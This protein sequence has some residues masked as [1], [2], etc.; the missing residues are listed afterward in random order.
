MAVYVITSVV[1]LGDRFSP[2]CPSIL[3][4]L[5]YPR[6]EFCPFPVSALPSVTSCDGDVTHELKV[7]LLLRVL[8]LP[9]TWWIILPVQCAS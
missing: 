3:S 2:W 4:S 5:P 6:L 7:S 8:H 9:L 1:S